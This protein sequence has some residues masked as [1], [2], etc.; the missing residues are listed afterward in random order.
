MGIIDMASL[1]EH[2]LTSSRVSIILISCS[3]N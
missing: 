3:V 2:E 1:E